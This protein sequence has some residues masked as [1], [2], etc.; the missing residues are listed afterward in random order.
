LT[1]IDN[2]T[3]RAI[4]TLASALIA[5]VSLLLSPG[6][7]LAHTLDIPETVVANVDGSFS[8]Q[9]VFTAGPGTATVAAASWFGVENVAGGLVADCFCSP[10]CILEEGEE[11]PVFVDGA[12]T[13]PT[14]PGLVSVEVAFCEGGTMSAEVQI[15]PFQISPIPTLSQWGLAMVTLLLLATGLLMSRRRMRI[16]RIP[17]PDA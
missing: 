12:L 13:D 8:F 14:A 4:R 17:V 6:S 3:V 11:L 16:K 7:G 1:P 2:S 10:G 5:F 15:L 9:A